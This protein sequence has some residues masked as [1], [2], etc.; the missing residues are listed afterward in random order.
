MQG[1]IGFEIYLS[2]LS[3]KI[4]EEKATVIANP[5]YRV[6]QSRLFLLEIAAVTS[7]P[8]NDTTKVTPMHNE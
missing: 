7:F 1:R 3:E 4:K 5:S 8:R 2:F 6:W